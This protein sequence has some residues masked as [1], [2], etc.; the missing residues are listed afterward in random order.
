MLRCPNVERRM[1]IINQMRKLRKRIEININTQMPK[2]RKRMEI[3]INAQMPK[4]RKKNA[5]Y[6]SDAQTLKENANY[7]I[8][9]PNVEREC[10]L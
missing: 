9:C 7:K 8:R 6:K 4:R 10:K 1:Q 2:R 5:N 3:N